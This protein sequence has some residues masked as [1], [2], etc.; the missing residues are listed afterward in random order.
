M[1]KDTWLSIRGIEMIIIMKSISLAIDIS[2]G[3]NFTGSIINYLSYFL[4]INTA[5]FGPWI[6]Y[7]SHLNYL[8]NKK[9]LVGIFYFIFFINK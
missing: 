5:V 9:S 2:N 4:S 3:L 6:S 7:S 1:N 8:N